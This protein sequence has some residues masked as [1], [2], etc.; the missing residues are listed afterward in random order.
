MS[1][2]TTYLQTATADLGEL[3]AHFAPAFAKVAEANLERERT[4]TFPHEQVS[5][6]NEAGFGTL[7]IPVD[8]GG[9]GAS[10]Q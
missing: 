4:R 7:R 2:A 1:S 5:L 8:R 6:L 3:R 9:F 10:L